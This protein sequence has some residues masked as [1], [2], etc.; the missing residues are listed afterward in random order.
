MPVHEDWPA[1][2]HALRLQIFE[3]SKLCERLSS[4][5]SDQRMPVDLAQLVEATR[6]SVLTAMRVAHLLELGA[7][8]ARQAAP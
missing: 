1:D 3:C 7:T 6:M 8:V 4:S 2:V 5:I